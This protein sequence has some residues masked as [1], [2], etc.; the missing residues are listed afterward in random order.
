M[1]K[2]ASPAYDYFSEVPENVAPG[3]SYKLQ[4]KHCNT[5]V[6]TN[7]AA[8]S[9]NLLTHLKVS[10]V[11]FSSALL[12]QPGLAALSKHLVSNLSANCLCKWTDVTFAGYSNQLPGIFGKNN[13]KLFI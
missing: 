10:M 1:P 8:A 6:S 3:Q 2:P 4:C 9:S 12:L 7:K 13:S 5:Q 11:C